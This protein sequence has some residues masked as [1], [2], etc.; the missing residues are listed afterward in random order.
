MLRPASLIRPSGAVLTFDFSLHP[1]RDENGEVIYLVPEGR[2]ITE[3]KELESRDAFLVGLDDATR[4]LTD[5]QEIIQTAA[6]LLG[7][8]L[9]VI[10]ALTRM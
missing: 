2:D 7:E 8:K 4:P 6:R 5:P 10:A 1:V 3:R 9:R